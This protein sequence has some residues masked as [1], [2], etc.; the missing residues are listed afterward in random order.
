MLLGMST[1]TF[2]HVAISVLAILSGIVVM[3][4][5]LVSKWR[6]GWT[7]LFL[8]TTAITSASGFGFARDQVLPS[9]VVS[10]ISLLVLAVAALALY[11]KHLIFKW[12]WIYVVAAVTALYL[13]VFVLIV[14]LFQKVPALHALA[15]TQAEPPF[16]IAQGVVLLAFVV[17]GFFAVR[18]FRP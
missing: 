14:Q 2:A 4:S 17:L 15:P 10:V 12:R 1:F 18:R 6:G 3:Q 11:G 16:A 5:L 9:H 7:A 8:L 13:N